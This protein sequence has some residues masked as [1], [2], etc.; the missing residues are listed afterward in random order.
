MKK[1]NLIKSL[2]AG[3]SFFIFAS[4][5][6]VLSN[7]GC[8]ESDNY[9]VDGSN[10]QGH[11]SGTLTCTLNKENHTSSI[12]S[13]SNYVADSTFTI[14]DFIMFQNEKYMVTSIG[15]SAF[16]DCYGIVSIDFGSVTTIDNYAFTNCVNIHKVNLSM[17][18]QIG[19]AAFAYCSLKSIKVS[20]AN[21]TYK[22][23]GTST[24]GY[25]QRIN[26][27]TIL[28][29][30]CDNLGGIACGNIIFPNN[31]IE[32]DGNAFYECCEITSVDFNKVTTIGRGG[33]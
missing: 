29:P 14:P 1:I 17:V 30:A 3:C 8:R 26:D 4:P 28:T 12:T 6:I 13:N 24:N 22:L 10:W 9:L 5:L 23:V 16:T 21:T 15:A 7:T 27:T 19:A 18:S 11:I 2:I 31:I 25:I 33:F 20:Q 32:I